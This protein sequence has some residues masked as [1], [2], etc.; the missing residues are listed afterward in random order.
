MLMT[1]DT[2]E[3]EIVLTLVT[4]KDCCLCAEMKDVTSVVAREFRARLEILDVD[5]D[6]ELKQRFS[7]EV[8]VLL[9]NGRR[10]FKY[11]V[12]AAELR[13]RLQREG[14]GWWRRFIPR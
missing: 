9:V 10:A 3:G 5:D 12:A 8:P 1:A 2:W 6:P 7:N 14:R 11:R 13:R 4:R